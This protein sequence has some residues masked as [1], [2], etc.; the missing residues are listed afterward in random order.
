MWKG[1]KGS[2]GS[3]ALWR[4][5]NQYLTFQQPVSE[6]SCFITKNTPPPSKEHASVWCTG[7]ILLCFL[8][9]FMTV[10]RSQPPPSLYFHIQC[11][12]ERSSGWVLCG[13]ELV[14]KGQEQ[15]LSKILNTSLSP[16]ICYKRFCIEKK[17]KSELSLWITAVGSCWLHRASRLL[18]CSNSTSPL[19]ILHGI[20]IIKKASKSRS[21][22]KPKDSTLLKI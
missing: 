18:A 21:R 11:Q 5:V 2:H 15:K 13:R 14:V 4:T 8:L 10:A 7:A 9:P 20:I 19:Q 1:T 12:S 17:N 3:T 6:D 16:N 22:E